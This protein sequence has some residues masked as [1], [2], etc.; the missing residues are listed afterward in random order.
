MSTTEKNKEIV[1]K[2]YDE[3]MNKRNMDILN[4]YIS[5]EFTGIAGKKGVT[6]FQEPIQ[7]L[8]KAMPDVQWTIQ[9]LIAE[10]D[11]VM[12]K[13]KI[14]GTSKAPFTGFGPTGKITTNEGM[15]VFTFRNGKIVSSQ[16]LTDRL[17]FLQQLEVLPQDLS[18]LAVKKQDRVLFI[19]K[20]LMPVSSKQEFHDRMNMNRNFIKNLPGFIEDDAY[21]YEDDKGNLVVVTVAQWKSMEAIEK[22]KEAVQVE[23]KRVGFDRNELYKRLQITVDRGVYNVVKE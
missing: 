15:G 22:A 7:M 5:D 17:N 11:K 13:W 6:A 10:G 19:D 3:A 1:Q 21:E 12:V 23:Y 9:E 4:N 2:I 18:V 14:Q 16:V 8:I 20:F